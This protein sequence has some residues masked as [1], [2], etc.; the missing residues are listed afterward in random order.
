MDETRESLA[1]TV[2]LL[3]NSGHG[4]LLQQ[5]LDQ[6]LNCVFPEVRL[7]LVSER[8]SPV[9]YYDKSHSKRSRFPGMSVLLFLHESLGEERLFR[10]L[11]SLQHWPWQCYPTQNVQGRPCPNILANQEFYS[12]DNQMPVWG[13]R[14]VRCGTEILRVTLYCSFD[15]Y[16]DAIRLYEMILQR[17]ATLQK[18]NFCFFV[19]YST[20]SFALQ[21]SLKQLPPGTSVDPKEAS[22]LQFQVQEIGQLVPLLPHPC[23]PISHTRWQTQDYDGNK[24]LLQVQLNPGLGVR[25]GELAFLNGTS[26]ADT[27]PQGSRLTPVSAIRT[28]EPRSRRSRGRRFKVGSVELPEPGGRTASNSSSGSSWKGPGRSSQ[29]S[30][31]AGDSQLHV[32][33]PHLEPGARMKVLSRENSLGKLEAETNVDTGFTVVSSEPRQSFLSRF[34]RDLRTQQPPSCLS[35]SSLG[36]GAYKNNGIFKERVHPLSPVAQ[37][38]LGARKIIS[39]C[40]LPLP[41]QGEEKEAAEEFFI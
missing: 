30:S 10:V 4:S 39:K 40:A 22:V 13:V 8:V 5:T 7:F 2:H 11:D 3:A 37:R 21:L 18:S 15:N 27:L 35:T 1:M 31:P 20:E 29:P 26:G 41:V 34:P 19:L 28:L 36:A 16:E 12:L 14:Q 9:K 38:D 24:I 25:S 6:L 32:P 17:E 23:V 33:S